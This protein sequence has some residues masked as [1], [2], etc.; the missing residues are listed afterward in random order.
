MQTHWA[1]HSLPGSVLEDSVVLEDAAAE[2][3]ALPSFLAN[4][5]AHAAMRDAELAAT[6]GL[7]APGQQWR[8][9]AW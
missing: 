8:H 3:A 7:L 1:A 4:G 9:A 2:E 6:P 5:S